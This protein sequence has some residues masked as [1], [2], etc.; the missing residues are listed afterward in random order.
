MFRVQ[1]KQDGTLRLESVGPN[2]SSWCF[3]EGAEYSPSFFSTQQSRNKTHLVALW[4]SSK[5]CLYSLIKW[6]EPPPWRLKSLLSSLGEKAAVFLFYSAATYGKFIFKHWVCGI[7]KGKIPA[8]RNLERIR[9]DWREYGPNHHV[10]SGLLHFTEGSVNNLTHRECVHLWPHQNCQYQ[11]ASRNASLLP[12]EEQPLW[13]E[14]GSATGI[15]I[16]AL[17]RFFPEN[18]QLTAGLT[19]NINLFRSARRRSGSTGASLITHGTLWD[20]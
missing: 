18:S 3:S 19:A 20:T 17:F 7:R 2:K 10:H 15:N 5:L 11:R 8:G 14:V 1:Q 16:H 4:N 6:E 12:D 9:A 13:T